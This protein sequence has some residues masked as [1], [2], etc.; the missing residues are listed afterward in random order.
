MVQQQIGDQPNEQR[1]IKATASHQTHGGTLYYV[2]EVPRDELAICQK[3]E[4]G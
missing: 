3:N 1:I 4:D 2:V